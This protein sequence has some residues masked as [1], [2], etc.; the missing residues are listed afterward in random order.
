MNK[1]IK[2]AL[3][4][5]S[6]LSIATAVSAAIDIPGPNGTYSGNG[7]YNDG[8]TFVSLYANQVN[9][10]SIKVLNNP[11]RNVTLSWDNKNDNAADVVLGAGWGWNGQKMPKN[12]SYK[13]NSWSI[14]RG[15]DS[16]NGVFGVYGWSC[17]GADGIKKADGT[18]ENNVEF[19][20]IDRWLGASQ[21]VP[22]DGATQMTPKGQPVRANGADY[23]IY[24]SSTYQ[25]ANACG[26]SDQKFHQVWAVR[27]GKK[28]GTGASG[29]TNIDMATIGARIANYGYITQNLRYIVVGVDAFKN[30]KGTITLGYVDRSY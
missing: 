6:A 18:P 21:Y 11:Y 15:S 20:V 19:Y 3:L 26:G 14:T 24:Q 10:S 27:Q 7:V 30:A 2:S 29:A 5:C 28:T 8:E 17:A 25:R 13:V 12:I 22:Y 1:N 16:N 4:I 23:K 9:S